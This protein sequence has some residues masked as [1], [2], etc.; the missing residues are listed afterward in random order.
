MFV[1]WKANFFFFQLFDKDNILN[2]K[3]ILFITYWAR[4]VCVCGG[5]GGGGGGWGKCA[6]SLNIPSKDIL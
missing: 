5:G 6:H 1:C 2:K 4:C 3:I